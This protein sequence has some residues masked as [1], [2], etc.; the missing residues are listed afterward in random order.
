MLTQEKYAELLELAREQEP[1]EHK[2]RLMLLDMID[3]LEKIVA[4]YEPQQPG[5]GK[6]RK[7]GL[8]R[9]RVRAS[10]G[11]KNPEFVGTTLHIRKLL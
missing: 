4:S 9:C 3:F 8:I 2:R 7:R 5:N 6:G 1:V 10:A 11:A